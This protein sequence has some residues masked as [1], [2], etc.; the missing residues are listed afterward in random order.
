MCALAA[1][2]RCLHG[3][4]DCVDYFIHDFGLGRNFQHASK[5]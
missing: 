5:K 4:G 1:I 2:V 3:G